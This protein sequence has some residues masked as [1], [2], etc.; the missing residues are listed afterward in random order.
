M[1]LAVDVAHF[2]Y[3]HRAAPYISSGIEREL[4]IDGM[5]DQPISARLVRNERVLSRSMP[6]V[7]PPYDG[8]IDVPG[9]VSPLLEWTKDIA[10]PGHHHRVGRTVPTVVPRIKR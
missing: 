3:E 10:G 8:T 2:V 6:V 4:R 5:V 1:W 7:A 9:D